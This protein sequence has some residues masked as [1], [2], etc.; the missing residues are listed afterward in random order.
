MYLFLWLCQVLAE[1]C[2]I[3]M[4]SHGI[5]PCGAKTLVVAHR[6]PEHMVPAVASRA[7]CCSPGM[8]HLS[9]P[10]SDQIWVPCIRRRIL[11]HWTTR[12]VPLLCELCWYF[13][14][15]QCKL[16]RN[17]KDEFPHWFLFFLIDMIYR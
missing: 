11:N 3:F 14:S 4:V 17:H 16:N 13:P 9:S 6:P 15:P 10:T 8:W 12:E 1:A 5:F 7:L 2:R